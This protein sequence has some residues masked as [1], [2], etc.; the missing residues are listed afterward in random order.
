MSHKF[1]Q[2][3]TD[4]DFA[5]HDKADKT[6]SR[7]SSKCGNDYDMNGTQPNYE[8]SDVL[9]RQAAGI[10][11]AHRLLTSV[12]A[13][14]LGLFCGAWSD[15]RGRKLPAMVPS[16][17][18]CLAVVLYLFSMQAHDTKVAFLLAGAS[19]QGIF[20]KSQLILMALNSYVLDTCDNEDRTKRLG[21][22]LG[23]T[24][25]GIFL[26]SFLSSILQEMYGLSVTL[27]VVSVCHALCM[28]VTL[29]GVTEQVCSEVLT[30]VPGYKQLS[31][32]LS[33]DIDSK[34]GEEEGRGG[35]RGG[36]GRMPEEAALLSWEGLKR[37][38]IVVVRKRDGQRRAI[39]VLT[40]ISI[41]FNHIL[42]IGDQDVTVLFVQRPPLSWHASFYGNLL[43]VDYGV[44][45]FA[46][47]FILPILTNVLSISD[48]SI[49]LIAIAFKLV[50]AVWAGF[51]TSTWMMFA[52]VAC[53]ALG[54]LINPGL[55]SILS[56]TVSGEE[57]GKL[58][59][60]QAAVETLSKLVGSGVFTG[61]YA[62]TLN[63][64]AP[65]AYLS[66][67]VV[68]LVMALLLLWLG[69][70]FKADGAQ[71]RSFST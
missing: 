37:S 10:V 68:F 21:R 58:F 13:I 55:R 11:V 56:K 31:S 41:A 36:G 52:S 43:A 27:V 39:I 3:D 67:A 69:R 6:V 34:D 32:D 50:R 51:C 33:D 48:T 5:S 30:T 2:P 40:L 12:P 44:M 9:Q 25:L 18:S 19:I 63:I 71:E 47:I 57:V 49:V 1:E 45:G 53:G 60:I 38:L 66:E 70:L 64:F 65:A 8:I 14:V 22:L 20:G 61:I 4:I 42:K 15:T 35:D 46:L 16:A 7:S 54:G 59:S 23:S 26:G 28:L 29:F 17:G 24:F 62:A